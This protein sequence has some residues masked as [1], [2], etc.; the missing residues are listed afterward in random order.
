M[1]TTGIPLVMPGMATVF[2]PTPVYF[3]MVIAPLLVV[4]VN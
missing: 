4:K 2:W 3:L 1:L